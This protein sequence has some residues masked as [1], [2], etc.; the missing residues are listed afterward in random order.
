V[1]F[2]IAK[3]CGLVA[4]IAGTSPQISAQR[5]RQVVCLGR[6]VTVVG[7]RRVFNQ[8]FLQADQLAARIKAEGLQWSMAGLSELGE[9][10]H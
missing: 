8:K 5:F 1:S 6:L 2:G 10:V 7:K 3:H 4:A 9:L